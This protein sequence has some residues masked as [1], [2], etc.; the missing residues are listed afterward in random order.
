MKKLH[1]LYFIDLPKTIKIV[2]EMTINV[3]SQIS[4]KNKDYRLKCL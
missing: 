1:L 4:E 3:H 2:F